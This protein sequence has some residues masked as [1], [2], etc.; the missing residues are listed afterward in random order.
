ME[1]VLGPVA[2]HA[3][4]RDLAIFG[5]FAEYTRDIARTYIVRVDQ[6]GDIKIF[7][8]I[9]FLSRTESDRY[10]SNREVS[11]IIRRAGQKAA[12]Q[13]EPIIR[14]RSCPFKYYNR[15]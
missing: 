6:K 12:R 1:A 11:I 13:D 3:A 8:I 4:D 7:H 5:Q 2:V 9:C 14:G 15:F 10:F